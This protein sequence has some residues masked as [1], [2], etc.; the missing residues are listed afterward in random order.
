[1]NEESRLTLLV[2]GGSSGLGLE[3]AR[4]FIGRGHTV[5]ACGRDEARLADAVATT[6]GLHAVTA[7]IG[8]ASDRRRLLDNVTATGSFDVLVNNAAISHAHDYTDDYTLAEDR[9]AEEL[10]VNLA[11]PIE[12]SRMFLSWRRA[13]GRDETP[14]TIAMIST[15]GALFPLEANP[16]Y[17]ASKAGLHNFT[18]ALRWQLRDTPVS[19]VEVFPPALA[20]GLSKEIDVPAEA[21]N[22]QEA[23]VDV[24]RRS[25]DGILAGERTVLPHRQSE[26]LYAAFGR[27]FSDN[28]MTKLNSG[29]T[30]QPGWNRR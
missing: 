8:I 14:A 9:A 27:E 7:D 20:T 21:E 12:L 24:A 28:F 25:V 15:P 10:A 3:L 17:T 5:F 23:V 18:L 6:P 26:Q 19:V 29:V 1:M 13:A 16:L 22:G 11:A 4:Q 30:R 2:T